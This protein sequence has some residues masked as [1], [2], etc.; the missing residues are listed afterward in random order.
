MRYRTTEPLFTTILPTVESFAPQRGSLYIS[1]ESIEER[2]RRSDELLAS[3]PDVRV[4][5]VVDSDPSEMVFVEGRQNTMVRSRS[6]RDIHGYLDQFHVSS[7]YL[8]ITGLSHRVW[9]P[10]LKAIRQRSTPARC[11][12]VEPGE[13]RR[14]AA[15]TEATI[16]DLSERIEGIAPLPGFVS[17]KSDS[18]T[19]S[20]FIPLLGFEG[21]RL[22]YM[23]ES[24]Q[25]N[26]RDIFPIIGVPG[27]RPE[28]VFDTYL[29]NRL[30]L[31]ETRAW[32]NV[33][34]AA[35]NCPFALYHVL[36][37]L[38]EDS[39][40]RWLR[41]AMIGTKPHAL[42]AVLY[43]LDHSTTTELLYDHPVRKAQRTSGA[44][45]LCLYDLSL[46]PPLRLERGRDG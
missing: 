3:W 22:A 18:P 45:R 31:I 30:Q 26:R 14:S 41:V 42:G 37:A 10:L 9:A 1:G 8:D 40:E 25:P 27:F 32:S 7:V 13:Y 29:G 19:N 12:Y 16:Y 38:A 20:L 46:L 6:S 36:T 24:A 21:T 2:S 35:A 43:Y 44:S 15:P 4:V 28:Y 34:Y 5:Q 39:V 17:L 11:V 33:R 23:L